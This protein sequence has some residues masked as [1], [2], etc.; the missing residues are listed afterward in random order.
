MQNAYCPEHILVSVPVALGLL[1]G[2]A[3]PEFD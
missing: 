1:A 3:T 2:I